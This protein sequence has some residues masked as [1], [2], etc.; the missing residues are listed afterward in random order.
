MAE[1]PYKLDPKIQMVANTSAPYHG[2][3]TAQRW[4]ERENQGVNKPRPLIR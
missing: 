3:V 4:G 1:N 2:M